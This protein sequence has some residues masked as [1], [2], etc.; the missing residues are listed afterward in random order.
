MLRSI[1]PELT[2]A[3][4]RE[5]GAFDH[6]RRTHDEGTAGSAAEHRGALHEPTEEGGLVVR[7]ETH[8][9]QDDRSGEATGGGHLEGDRRTDAVPSHDVGTDVDRQLR[10][11]AGVA[12]DAE[13]GGWWR[14]RVA[15]QGHGYQ[16]D[17]GEY[18]FGHHLG[19][20]ISAAQASGEKEHRAVRVRWT[21]LSALPLHA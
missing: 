4:V 17:A 6:R 19:E 21:R 18:R 1:S 9:Q 15:R 13:I 16:V 11:L 12:L 10:G 5:C 14:T 3:V 7:R 2:L 8:T 20:G